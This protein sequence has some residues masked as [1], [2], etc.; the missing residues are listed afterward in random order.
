VT[1][2]KTKPS[3]PRRIAQDRAE[4]GEGITEILKRT[5]DQ[6][7]HWALMEFVNERLEQA[8]QAQPR[9]AIIPNE[10]PGT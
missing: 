10:A 2:D 7:R 5:D 8:K 4:L 9:P 3:W 6:D 1:C